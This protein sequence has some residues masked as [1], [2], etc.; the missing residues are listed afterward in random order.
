MTGLP[1]FNY[2]AFM[3][4]E[5]RLQ[6]VGYEVLNP[7]RL[8]ERHRNQD[9]TCPCFTGGDKHDWRWYMDRC[10]PLVDMSQALALL[11]GWQNSR[12]ARIEVDRALNHGLYLASVTTWV[13]R[14]KAALSGRLGE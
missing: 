8:D 10:L 2:P 13:H 1:Q 4:A 7:A 6:G 9:P 5:E 14:H 3:E 11:P 12:G